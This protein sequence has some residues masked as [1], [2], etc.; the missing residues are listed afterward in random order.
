MKHVITLKHGA[1]YKTTPL[2]K[3][4]EHVFGQENLFGNSRDVNANHAAKVAVTATDEAGKTAIILANYSREDRN[5]SKR[6]K[7]HYDF[8]RPD[9]PDLELKIWEAAAATFAAPTYFKPFVHYLTKRCYLDGAIYNNNPVRLVH[10]ERKLLWP[11]VAGRHPD[12]LL[13]IG[14]GQN[15][16]AIKKDLPPGPTSTRSTRRSVYS[17]IY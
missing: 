2:R 12:I 8:P 13:S 3:A 14:T 1:K 6:R 17:S 5:R 16:D 4:L 11:D 10:R 15:E 7:S 9:N